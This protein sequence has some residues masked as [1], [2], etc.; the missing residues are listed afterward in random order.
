MDL[1]RV[2]K[3]RRS[4]RRFKQIPLSMDFLVN[5]VDAGRLA[6]S[7][8]N[9]QPIEYVIVND[10]R[11]CEKI[12]SALRWAGYIKPEWRPAEGERPV[13]YIVIL[14]Q[15][16]RSPFS[17]VDVGLSA[18]NIMLLAWSHGVGSCM[19]GNIDREMIREILGV[20]DGYRIH[21]V[22]ALGFPA[23]KSVV[24]ESDAVEYWRDED[25]VMHVPKRRIK[26]IVH[27][28][29]FGCRGGDSNS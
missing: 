19:L 24:E 17:D 5:L 11:I 25:G 6:P 22:I 12:F 2:I 1:E 16:G 29:R 10:K 3:T 9:L 15:E 27:I 21:S 26:D 14:V 4:I 7:G 28:N 20:P 8:A 23:E 13:A 18:E